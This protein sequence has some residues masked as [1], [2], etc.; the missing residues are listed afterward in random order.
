MLHPLI[1]WLLPARAPTAAAREG[2][3]SWVR[4]TCISEA[5]HL[6]PPTRTSSNS[7]NREY[8]EQL[9]LNTEVSLSHLP[10]PLRGVLGPVVL[11]MA[12]CN[13]QL[14][15]YI[16][17]THSSLCDYSLNKHHSTLNVFNVETWFGFHI[18][19]SICS[20]SV[21]QETIASLGKSMSL[22]TI[23]GEKSNPF[24]IYRGT[25]LI[26]HLWKYLLRKKK[27]Q[28]ENEKNMFNANEKLSPSLNNYNKIIFKQLTE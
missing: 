13:V 24:W 16:T 12:V 2:R 5:C 20:T 7:A 28:A 25:N 9:P 27:S 11:L 6:G 22:I 3:S 10:M 17:P 26:C 4:P 23:M 21:L 14:P 1:P 8:S 19:L 15:L 18:N